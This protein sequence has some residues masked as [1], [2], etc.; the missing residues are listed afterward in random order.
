MLNL[1][2]E[3]IHKLF[4]GK[5]ENHSQRI[6]EIKEIAY[7]PSAIKLISFLIGLM[8]FKYLVKRKL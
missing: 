6:T 8:T 4:L 1:Y 3:D 2:T 5:S 7:M